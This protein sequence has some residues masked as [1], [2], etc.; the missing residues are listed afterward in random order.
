MKVDITLSRLPA[1]PSTM[2]TYYGGVNWVILFISCGLM[3]MYCMAYQVYPRWVKFR[4]WMFKRKV[5]ATLEVMEQAKE[6]LEKQQVDAITGEVYWVQDRLAAAEELA[7]MISGRDAETGAALGG[8]DVVLEAG[9]SKDENGGFGEGAGGGQQRR[10]QR[11]VKPLSPKKIAELE[12]KRQAKAA[13]EEACRRAL[14]V[15]LREERLAIVRDSFEKWIEGGNMGWQLT[16]EHKNKIGHEVINGLQLR[17]ERSA[18]FF[19]KL[20]FDDKMDRA[21][22]KDRHRPRDPTQRPASPTSPNRGTAAS[23]GQEGSCGARKQSP[24]RARS[25][26]PNASPR[27]DVTSPEAAVDSKRAKR[28]AKS[29]LKEWEASLVPPAVMDM[30][31]LEERPLSSVEKLRG[32]VLPLA[33]PLRSQTLPILLPALA[34]EE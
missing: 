22:P 8:L 34:N 20:T 3:F 12:A 7:A 11:K 14:Y 5:N 24:P 10:R 17:D 2:A 31:V 4:H 30:P 13:H 25:P 18:S 32:R 6:D 29:L 9:E 26:S 16:V 19:H 28:A 15:P 33:K 27:R 23:M 21:R 1:V